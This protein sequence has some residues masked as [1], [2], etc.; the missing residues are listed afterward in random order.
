[1]IVFALL[2]CY[3]LISHESIVESPPKD[4]KST[5]TLYY[6]LDSYTY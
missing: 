5:V 4:T 6:N 2:L 3:T 1:M